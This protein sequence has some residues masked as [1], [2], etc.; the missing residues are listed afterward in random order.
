MPHADPE[1]PKV[2][3]VVGP[4]ASGKTS[5]SITIAQHC[6]GEVISADSRQVYRGLDIGTGKVTPTEMAGVPHHLI[7]IVEPDVIY[8]AAD[9]TRDATMALDDI[10][11]R[12]RQ[13]IVA[14]GS[15]FYLELLRGRMQAAPVPPNE[16]LRAKLAD[17]ST[18]ALYTQLEQADPRRARSID[19]HNRRRLIRA[20]EIVAEL[21]AVPP[22]P[23]TD[24]PY[25]WL[26][27]G[28]TREPAELR[29]RFRAR[30]R[31]WLEAGF[32]A[33]VERLQASGVSNAR[34]EEFGF[35]YTLMQRHLTGELDE[36]A[37]IER[38][39]EQNWQ[40]AKRQFTWLKRDESIHW[41]HPTAT[42]AILSTVTDWLAD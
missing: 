21:G 36:A 19:P 41:F 12:E 18:D 27:I 29:E 15:F 10:L 23:S 8:T 22:A 28:L 30:I 2:V 4:T 5:L 13:P 26:L 25:H 1:K 7:D 3:A 33:E 42:D 24:S 39:V 17:Y 16:A 20:L 40:Y 9:F 37:L 38:F 31:S 6:N 11:A 32:A 14:G 35:E 34:L